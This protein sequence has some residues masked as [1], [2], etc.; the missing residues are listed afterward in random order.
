MSAMAE[1]V[2]SWVVTEF[3]EAELGDVRRTQRLGEVA[4]MLALATGASLPEA[5]GERA[6]L[7]AAYRFFDSARDL[8]QVCQTADTKL[9][10]T[11]T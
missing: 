5:C 3:A 2:S 7:K 1:E 4:T 10:E 6:M 11:I 8:A 9:V